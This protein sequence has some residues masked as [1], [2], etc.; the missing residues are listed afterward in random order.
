[1][2]SVEGLDAAYG[3][4]RVLYGVSVEVCDG[5]VTCVVGRN[6]AGKTTL[7]N[8]VM[9]VLRPTSGRVLWEGQDIT[10]MPPERRVQ[11]GLGYVPQGHPVFP[12]LSVEE[13]LRVVLEARR[14]SDPAAVDDALDLFPRLK[15]LMGRRAGVLSGGQQQQLAIARAL[16]GRPR[17]LI[18]DEP[19]EGIQP[20]IIDEIEDA[21]AELHRSAGM[22]I[23]LIE[24]YVEFA[25]RLADAYVALDAGAVLDSGPTAN[26]EETDVRRLLAV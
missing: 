20:S 5:G 17:L 14:G 12:Q 25:L 13:N 23:L 2:L 18:M 10:R 7:V 26:L 24:Q 16:V 11:L 22:S 3:R 1:M 21:I 19:T 15:A 4:T 8:A 9:G 6:G